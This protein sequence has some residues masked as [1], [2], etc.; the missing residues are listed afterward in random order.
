MGFG[1]GMG[2]ANIKRCVDRMHLDSAPGRG[3]VL[4][5]EIFLTPEEGFRESSYLEEKNE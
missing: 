1:A 4:D 3:S 2:L 5:M